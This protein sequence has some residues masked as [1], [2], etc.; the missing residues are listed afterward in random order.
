MKAISRARIPR[1]GPRAYF[2]AIRAIEPPVDALEAQ[3]APRRASQVC[4]RRFSFG[5]SKAVKVLGT[6][7]EEDLRP[8]PENQPMVDLPRLQR[9]LSELYLG[10]SKAESRS[11]AKPTIV[12]DLWYD[13]D[14]F[15]DK[16]RAFES[17]LGAVQSLGLE[18]PR[19]EFIDLCDP[20]FQHRNPAGRG[21]AI[22]DP[23][24][25]Q[26]AYSNVAPATIPPI[27]LHEQGHIVLGPHAGEDA[28]DYF[29]GFF[30]EV[31][32]VSMDP[33]LESIEDEAGGNDARGVF[34]S[35]GKDRAHTIE[36]GQA[37]ARSL[38]EESG[39][40]PLGFSVTE[41]GETSQDDAPVDFSWI[42]PEDRTF[43]VKRPGAGSYEF[44]FT[45]SETVVYRSAG[46]TGDFSTPPRRLGRTGELGSL[47]IYQTGPDGLY[48]RRFELLEKFSGSVSVDASAEPV[49]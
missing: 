5:R 22:F 10:P 46:S 24:T 38:M 11:A 39:Q 16:Y 13:K 33:F 40:R 36:Q 6:R 1:V 2:E 48:A 9:D 34:Y 25:I 23:K 42:E 19:A 29:A 41:A 21:F 26:L 31:L 45:S 37:F 32:G 49:A 12:N 44:R 30:S 8:P 15:D 18:V 3:I 4:R 47:G 28:A 14:K 17:I 43:T 20:R 7:P 27:V 35:S